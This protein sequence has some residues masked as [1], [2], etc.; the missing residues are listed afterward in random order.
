MEIAQN[1]LI[2]LTYAGEAGL[3]R[4]TLLTSLCWATVIAPIS[5]RCAKTPTVLI[6]P[7]ASPGTISISAGQATASTYKIKASCYTSAAIIQDS[8][9]NPG[10]VPVIQAAATD[11][12]SAQ[13]RR[14]T[15]GG[16]GV[17][18]SC[19]ARFSALEPI[20]RHRQSFAAT[21]AQ[22]RSRTE[23]KHRT[24]PIHCDNS[25]WGWLPRARSAPPK[26][27]CLWR[28]LQPCH[29]PPGSRGQVD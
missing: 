17:G 28:R 13:L 11:Q 14:G 29:D 27:V 21:A 25:P 22:R 26:P 12:P 7:I 2:Y 6:Q 3:E 4:R 19:S 15:G 9:S 24:R 16:D 8:D 18:R 23:S 1:A 10:T 5:S 20:Q